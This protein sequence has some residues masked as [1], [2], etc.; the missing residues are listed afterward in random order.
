MLFRE[1]YNKLPRQYRLDYG[2]WI[3]NT[4]N[5]S[6]KSIMMA[7]KIDD[8]MTTSNL[9]EW[10]GVTT[11]TTPQGINH[12]RHRPGSRKHH[13]LLHG[14]EEKHQ[15]ALGTNAF[16]VA[17]KQGRISLRIL[18]LRFINKENGRIPDPQ[19]LTR[20]WSSEHHHQREHKESPGPERET[21]HIHG[22]RDGR[23]HRRTTCTPHRLA[24]RRDG[25]TWR[26]SSQTLQA[27]LDSSGTT[28]AGEDK[29]EINR[30][31]INLAISRAFNIV[32]EQA[33]SFSEALTMNDPLRSSEL[34]RNRTKE[35]VSRHRA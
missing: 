10:I 31:L 13:T 32:E 28:N 30:S 22:L 29:K 23:P 18:P 12:L 15:A 25:T 9:L 26:S 4:M 16:G 2:R 27:R 35:T 33:D 5:P 17:L 3:N 11:R 14:S 19:R 1:V 24:E 21:F 6:K 20:R 7:K 8:L 34:R